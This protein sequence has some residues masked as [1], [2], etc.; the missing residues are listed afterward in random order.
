MTAQGAENRTLAECALAS[1]R[2]FEAQQ[3]KWARNP[4]ADLYDLHVP[5]AE[6]ILQTLQGLFDS[7]MEAAAS[8][9]EGGR[10]STGRLRVEVCTDECAH[11]CEVRCVQIW[12][13]LGEL[14]V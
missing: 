10:S 12:Q 2:L 1:A 14:E 13:R 8:C 3:W 5:D 6:R 9:G 4:S 7:A 11:S